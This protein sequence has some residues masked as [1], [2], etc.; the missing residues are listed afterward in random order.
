[1]TA[2]NLNKLST[3]LTKHNVHKLTFLI[4]RYDSKEILKHLWEIKVD[5]PVTIATL[6]AYNKST[7]PELWNEARKQS[8]EFI[9]GLLMIAIIFSHH[10]LLEVFSKASDGEGTFSGK[11]VRGVH[12]SQTKEHTN[13][14]RVVGQLGFRVEKKQN[15]LSMIL[16]QFFKMN[17]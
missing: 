13:T 12:F 10:R 4:Q 3:S 16:V 1:M 8:E 6:S 7:A 15:T 11:V 14:A 2:I 5:R 9:N 17:Y